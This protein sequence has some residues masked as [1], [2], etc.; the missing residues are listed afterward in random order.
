MGQEPTE[1]VH[2]ASGGSKPGAAFGKLQ[3]G[4]VG[5]ILR[6]SSLSHCEYSTSISYRDGTRL[7]IEMGC[8]AK[9]CQDTILGFAIGCVGEPE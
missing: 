9:A 1:F 4:F 5:L 3:R 6:P 2:C 7:A 8:T